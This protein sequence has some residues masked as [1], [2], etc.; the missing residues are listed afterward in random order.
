MSSLNCSKCYIIAVQSVILIDI[1]PVK[2]YP[3]LKPEYKI[4]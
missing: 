1:N 3:H 2:L 4:V